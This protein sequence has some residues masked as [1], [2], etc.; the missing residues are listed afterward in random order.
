MNAAT[1]TSEKSTTPACLVRPSNG[2]F[3]D[4]K[5]QFRSILR[6]IWRQTIQHPFHRRRKVSVY[7]HLRL[8][9]VALEYGIHKDPVLGVDVGLKGRGYVLDGS[10]AISF[11]LL[12]QD[13]SKAQ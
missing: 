7:R 3:A 11:R 6:V 4:N 2:F 5:V 9:W 10:V 13:S 12:K 1:S 8:L